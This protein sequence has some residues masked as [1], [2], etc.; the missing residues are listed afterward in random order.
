[1]IFRS[2]GGHQ[3]SQ[4]QVEHGTGFIK[5]IMKLVT[6]QKSIIKIQDLGVICIYIEGDSSIIILQL[7]HIGSMMGD[8]LC[9]LDLFTMLWTFPSIGGLLNIERNHLHK[10]MN[11]KVELVAAFLPKICLHVMLLALKDVFKGPS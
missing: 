8:W 3:W 4:D 7:E 1:M 11:C 10:H 6:N 9:I 5:V 2:D